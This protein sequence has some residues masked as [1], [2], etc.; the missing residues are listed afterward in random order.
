M[1]GIKIVKES[2]L[3][4]QQS[5]MN[6]LERSNKDLVEK[7]KQYGKDY[8]ELREQVNKLISKSASLRETCRD[9]E[10]C[11][12]SLK[13]KLNHRRPRFED[14]FRL[15]TDNQKCTICDKTNKNT[16]CRKFTVGDH[17][18]CIVPLD[19]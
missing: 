3:A 5:R 2:A 16:N 17:T 10:E 18:V 19:Y 1:F 14:H 7:V 8:V 13:A 4:E 6:R 12:K 11:I 15:V 9:K